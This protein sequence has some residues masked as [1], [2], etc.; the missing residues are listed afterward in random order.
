MTGCGASPLTL[1]KFNTRTWHTKVSTTIRPF[2]KKE[3]SASL[4]NLFMISWRLAVN[5]EGYRPG[6]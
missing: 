5:C 6:K 3:S 1:G 2:S 4:T